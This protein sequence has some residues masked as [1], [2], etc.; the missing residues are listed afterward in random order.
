MNVDMTRLC[1]AAKRAQPGL[2]LPGCRDV[3]H[4]VLTE[5]RAIYSERRDD[6]VADFVASFL[7]DKIVMLLITEPLVVHSNDK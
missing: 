5:L 2:T 1:E 6:D 7:L 3:V 4:A